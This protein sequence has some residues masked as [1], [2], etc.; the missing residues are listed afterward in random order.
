MSASSH[1]DIATT[2]NRGLAWIG[3]ASSMVW[4][5]DILGMFIVLGLWIPP[6]QMGI[7]ALAIPFFPALDLASEMGLGAAVVQRDDHTEEKISTIFWFNFL[8]SVVLAVVLALGIGPALGALHDQPI[9]G[10]MFMA[11]AGKLVW[12]NTFL[13]PRALMRRQLRFG[14]LSLIRTLANVG[15]FV[16]LIAA[17]WAGFGIWCFVVG[18]ICRVLVTGVGIQI[19][20]PWRPRF[21]LQIRET[22]DWLV[23]GAKAASSQIVYH[24]YTNIDYQII[25]F[26][27]TPEETGLYW[28]AYELVLKPCFLIGEALQAIAFAAYSRL[29]AVRAQLIEQFIS[30][31]RLSLVVMLGFLV[32]I[33]VLADDILRLI[34]GADAVPAAAAARIL[35]GVGVLRALSFV[36]PPLLDGVG[37]PGLSLTYNALAAFVLP[38]SFLVCAQTLSDQVGFL[39][40][41]I[42]WLLG[43]PVVFSLLVYFTLTEVKLPLTTYL[44]RTIGI[45]LCAAA[46]VAAGWGTRLLLLEQSLV[47]RMLVPMLVLMTTYL[48]FLAYTQGVS[49]RSVWRS[50][51]GKGEKQ[52]PAPDEVRSDDQAADE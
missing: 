18:P 31:T 5:L 47:I 9:V 20:H 8:G 35:C 14:E 3:M 51:R 45:P 29:K 39:S 25:G 43:Y 26:M 12:H 2:V 36:I 42:G 19:C 40:V 10:W 17:A 23:F 11:Y 38:L 6:D 15:Q 32:I 34:W 21:V 37:R 22:T 27:F 52:S 7:A 41:A 50:A 49:P 16:G 24:I 1:S 4:L 44:R 30:F 28:F 48:L 46:G 13:I 33:M